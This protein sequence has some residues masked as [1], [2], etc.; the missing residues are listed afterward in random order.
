MLYGCRDVGKVRSPFPS[1]GNRTLEIPTFLFLLTKL[2][3]V[4]VA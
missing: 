2:D 1:T 4:L 3:I